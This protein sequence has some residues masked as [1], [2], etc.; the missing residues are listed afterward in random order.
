MFRQTANETMEI[1]LAP[2]SMLSDLA[3][4]ESGGFLPSTREVSSV[5]TRGS[6][7]NRKG[8]NHS[9]SQVSV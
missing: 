1:V 7:S 8:L 4:L 3:A 5:V 9:K 2:L 6:M